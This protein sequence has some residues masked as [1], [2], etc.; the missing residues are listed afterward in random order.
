MALIS[1]ALGESFIGGNW[2]VQLIGLTLIYAIVSFDAGVIYAAVY[3][4]AARWV[5]GMQI[6]FDET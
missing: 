3:N 2:F 6:E 4:L 1:S 5:G